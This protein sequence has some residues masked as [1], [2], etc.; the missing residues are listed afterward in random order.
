MKIGFEAHTSFGNKVNYGSWTNWKSASGLKR[1]SCS[2]VPPVELVTA[3]HG[4]I[5][6]VVARLGLYRG[7]MGG[8]G[9]MLSPATETQRN[10]ICASME[11]FNPVSRRTTYSVPAGAS[12]D[13]AELEGRMKEE[14]LEAAQAN[15][16]R[17]WI[18]RARA[19]KPLLEA[20][21]PRINKLK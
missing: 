21:A 1:A 15:V 3:G 7:A 12:A 2:A 10:W 17:E 18:G 19:L 8:H 11:K 20:A 4:P 6:K 9:S 13:V 16:E 5:R 14:S